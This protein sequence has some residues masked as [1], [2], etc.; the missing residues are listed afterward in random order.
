M[1]LFVDLIAAGVERTNEA[2]EIL[3]KAHGADDAGIWE[4]HPS[5]F[6]RRLVELFTQ[7]GLMRL[8][9][10]RAE[11]IAWIRGERH[12]PGSLLPRPSGAMQRWSPEELGLVNLYLES[13]SPDAWGLDDHMMMVDYVAQR[14]LPASDM[15]TEAEWLASRAAMMGRIQANLANLTAGEADVVLQALPTT[16]GDVANEFG[17]TPRMR[18]VMEFAVNRSAEAVTNLSDTARHK[19]RTV[20]AQ[21]LERADL[22]GPSLETEL[23]D[24]FGGLNRD[25][26]RIAVTEAT[27]AQCQGFIAMVG[28]GKR[29]KRVEIYRN[30][31][32]WCASIHGRIFTVVDASKDDK[33]GNTEVWV[34]KTNVG[35][36]VA[37]RKRVGDLLVER[38]PEELY[39]VAA[40]AQHPHC[41]GRWVAVDD[42][43]GTDPE[44]TRWARARLAAA[45]K[46]PH[47]E[48]QS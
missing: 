2:L 16:I 1:G 38:E 10:F 40:G 27:E 33:D 47:R 28:A 9:G 48:D 18:A 21:R 41:R 13:L 12:R 15:R 14:H 42:E 22:R 17:V 31:C 32:A 37:P 43:V 19:M 29:V 24:A 39:W 6:V 23:G 26:R 25:M 3:C 44:F 8:D 46:K 20:V 5:P 36:S 34:G 11:V 35:R 4:E 45:A 7:R 30:C